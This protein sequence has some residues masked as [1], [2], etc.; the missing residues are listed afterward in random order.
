MFPLSHCITLLSSGFLVAKH[1]PKSYVGS[2]DRGN[3]VFGNHGHLPNCQPKT[4]V[5][6]GHQEVR[7]YWETFRDGIHL[8]AGV[9]AAARYPRL[10][11]HMLSTPGSWQRPAAWR[12]MATPTN[13]NLMLNPKQACEASCAQDTLA[14]A[15]AYISPATHPTSSDHTS[16]MPGR[17]YRS[18]PDSRPSSPTIMAPGKLK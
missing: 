13:R 2:L 7:G 15:R 17:S 3:D 4:Q 8:T 11:F 10:S 5:Q 18:G 12:L 14:F 9:I 1:F 6:T 16:A